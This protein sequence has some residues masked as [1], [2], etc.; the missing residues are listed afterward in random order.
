[1]TAAEAA[2]P[3]YEYLLRSNLERVFNERDP[4]KRAAALDELYVAEP[5]MYEPT[6]VVR[7]GLPS[8]TSPAS[9]W[10]SLG[11]PSSLRRP[12]PLWGT[13]DWVRCNGKRARMAAPSS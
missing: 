10:N 2:E 11:P 6:N 8:L 13:T 4:A 5:V 7:G 3:D 1:M 9:C 12:A